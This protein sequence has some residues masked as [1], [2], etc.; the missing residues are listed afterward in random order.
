MKSVALGDV[1]DFYSGG[2]PSKSNAEFWKGEVPWFSAKDMKQDRLIDSADHISDSAFKS[3]SLRRLPAG[4]IA[5]VVRGMILA[6]TVPISI[7]EV[8]AAI[9][10]DL[11]ALIPKV[12]VD[13]AY[14]AAMLRAQHATIL[15]KVS[16]AAHGT[17]KLDTRVLEAVEI[18]L[19]TLV[20]QRRIASILDQADALRTKRRQVLTHLD[21]LTRSI[22]HDMFGDSSA[23]R[24]RIGD[25]AEVRSGSTPSRDDPGNYGGAIPW[26]KTGEV[27]GGV[28]TETAE[29]VTEKGAATAR[30]RLF[31]EGSV[32]VAMYGQGKTRGQS[33]I[34]G[35]PATTNQAC[36]VI[37][38]TDSFVPSF[39][40]AQLA[41]SYGRLRGEAEGGNQPNLSLGRVAGFEVLLP[42]VVDQQAFAARIK[43]TDA[44][45][46]SVRRAHAADNEFFASLQSRA[47]QGDL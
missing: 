24:I 16:T 22:F 20:E 25:F 7:L 3:T 38:P 14:L 34:L 23:T 30:L 8:P 9:N 6:H 28:I 19:P 11:K 21:A 41:L 32:L 31:P 4:T 5:M 42:D 36:A 17:K 45:R 37:L 44:Q 1:V 39:L 33:A 12:D 10:Q 47:F 29:H 43:R 40:Q 2:T 15:A 18:P 27:Q 13:T 26:V 46:S 35:I